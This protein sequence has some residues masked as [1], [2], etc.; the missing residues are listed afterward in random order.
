MNFSVIIPTMWKSDLILEMLPI[1]EKTK[2]IKEVII[3]DNDTDKTPD[4][5]PYKKVLHV[6]QS[7]N[8]FVNPAWNLGVALANHEIILANDDIRILDIEG[9]LNIYEKSGYDLIGLDLLHEGKGIEPM[10][11]FPANCFGSL[12]YVK[13]LKYLN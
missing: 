12:M 1:Y 6:P 4:F 11:R 8:I 7:Q 2:R 13:N 3:I 10:P 5:R 9:L